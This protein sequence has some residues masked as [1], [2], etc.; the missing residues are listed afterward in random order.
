VINCTTIYQLVCKID[1]LNICS[2]HPDEQFVRMAASRGGSFHAV[3]GEL[4][5]YLDKSSIYHLNG[6]VY[7]KTVRANKIH[8]LING[9][10][11]LECSKYSDTL[12]ATYHHWLKQQNQLPSQHSSTWPHQ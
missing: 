2:G 8:R 3:S 4:S 10:K 11:H 5:A 6:Q 12:R 9:V 7:R 1:P